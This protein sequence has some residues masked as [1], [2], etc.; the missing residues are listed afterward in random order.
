MTSAQGETSAEQLDRV[1]GPNNYG[2]IDFESG[3]HAWFVRLMS[4]QT[5][6]ARQQRTDRADCRE[7]A[8]QMIQFLHN[9]LGYPLPRL[10]IS[11]AGGVTEFQLSSRH[12]AGFKRGLKRTAD[13]THA[14]IV[15]SGSDTG[16]AKYVGEAISAA[17]GTRST[18][19][20]ADQRP[21]IG[22]VPAGVLG[23]RQT[24]RQ[25]GQ[26]LD[27]HGLRVPGKDGTNDTVELNRNHNTFFLVDAGDAGEGEFGHEL[28]H[29]AAFEEAIL[30]TKLLDPL[31]L[32]IT[33]SHDKAVDQIGTG[34]KGSTLNYRGFMRRLSSLHL[35]PRKS[36]LAVPHAHPLPHKGPP[37]HLDGLDSGLT[38]S[39]V[40]LVIEGGAGTLTIVRDATRK[41]TPVVVMEGSG[42]VADVLCYAWRFFH[43]RSADARGLSLAGL[44]HVI[45]KADILGKST[46]DDTNPELLRHCMDEV[47]R[48]VQVETHVQVYNPELVDLETAVM[49]ALSRSLRLT[50]DRSMDKA[51]QSLSAW[52]RA[53]HYTFHLHE[54]YLALVF[55]CVDKAETA[56]IALERVAG[57]SEALVARLDADISGALTWA[58][59]GRKLNFIKLLLPRVDACSYLYTGE[60]ATLR[61]ILMPG[62][63]EEI[64]YVQALSHAS[65]K[66]HTHHLQHSVDPDLLASASSLLCIHP[67]IHVEA[68]AECTL[69]LVLEATNFLVHNLVLPVTS[70]RHNK[71]FLGEP[72]N[73]SSAQGHS[74]L[75]QKMRRDHAYLDLAVWATLTLQSD[76]AVY[77]WEC[78]GHSIS[79]AL[80]LAG[81][82]KRLARY[83]CLI[84]HQ[85]FNESILS[86]EALSAQFEKMATGLLD[87]CYRDDIAMAQAVLTRRIRWF[88]SLNGEYPCSSCMHL[89][90]WGDNLTFLSHAASADVSER[91]WLGRLDPE[92]P[93]W[94]ITFG[95]VLLAVGGQALHFV[96]NLSTDP[97]PHPTFE[98]GKDVGT[99]WNAAGR[100]RNAHST[101]TAP[102]KLTMSQLSSTH[103][104]TRLMVQQASFLTVWRIKL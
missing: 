51:A 101:G 69:A 39:G 31:H 60:M 43:D 87:V 67:P 63:D 28:A 93:K 18:A 86:M 71:K 47:L 56:I 59:I 96:D 103:G 24:L 72:F 12:A 91:N 85:K 49:E 50:L 62:Q 3:G 82:L 27:V 99:Y 8:G 58:F 20:K 6:Q 57:R 41:Q 77:L 78:G 54:F 76:L 104:A 79:V 73:D 16:V 40:V 97:E 37:P 1:F 55:D 70:T 74:L 4:D 35:H 94:R 84:G 2:T 75:R 46:P 92:Q 19:D 89:A 21:V 64:A 15:T 29:R 80:F 102:G 30:Q 90:I 88:R 98:R 25:G 10:V 52:S 65:R 5:R 95:W 33:H 9:T 100:K 48:I 13:L 61:A 7:H 36:F 23:A 34:P 81:L 38:I 83:G 68:G 66:V 32:G 22:I 26:L 53:A 11:V 14:W 44:R 17:D 42:R 45:R